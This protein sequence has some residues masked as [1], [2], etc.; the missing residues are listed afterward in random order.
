MS[1]TSPL[2]AAAGDRGSHYSSMRNW[3]RQ[4]ADSLLRLERRVTR[5]LLAAD[6]DIQA[7]EHAIRTICEEQDWLAGS[8]W[9]V[10]AASGLLRQLLRWPRMPGTLA[11][12][13]RGCGPPAWLTD[14]PVW[15]SESLTDELR[16]QSSGIWIPPASSLVLPIRAGGRLSAAVVFEH[17]APQDPV[18]R[19]Q[20]DTLQALAAALHAYAQ[21]IRTGS[22]PF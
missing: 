12:P 9:R 21:R 5:M 7:L 13:G 15:V 1:S 17:R 16:A 11:T 2:V 8:F 4:T 18:I 10:D 20:L 19:Q 6:A 22:A 14:E 3:R